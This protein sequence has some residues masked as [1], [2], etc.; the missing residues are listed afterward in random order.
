MYDWRQDKFGNTYL[1]AS[2]PKMIEENSEKFEKSKGKPAKVYV[3]PGTPGKT[4]MKNEGAMVD[5]DN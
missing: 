3:T 1:E 2:M 4:S 5:L